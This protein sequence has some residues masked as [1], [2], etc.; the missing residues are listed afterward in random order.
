MNIN[1]FRLAIPHLEKALEYNP[2]ASS[3]VQMLADLYSRA[4]PD[5][6]KYLKYAL[7]GLQ[8]DI[9]AN[10]SI[11]KSYMYLALSNAFIQN[12]FTDKA[13]EYIDLSLDYNPRELLCTLFKN[14]YSVC[15]T[16]KHG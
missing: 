4:I 5:T 15:K 6:G 2:N 12:G 1:E 13:L 10:D 9:E 7:I 8:L 14:I 3:V 11:T 16:P